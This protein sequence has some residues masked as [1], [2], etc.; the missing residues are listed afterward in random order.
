MKALFAVLNMGL[1]HATRSLGLINSLMEKGVEITVAST[2]RSLHLLKDEFKDSLYSISFVDVPDYAIEYSKKGPL[3]LKLILQIPSLFKK[4]K[5]ENNFTEK[6]VKKNKYDLIISDHRYGF[7]HKN[8]PSFFITHQL[9]L[10]PPWKFKLAKKI[11]AK[12]HSLLL[13]NFNMVII[14][15]F[16]DDLNLSGEL[17]HNIF[18]NNIKKYYAGPWSSIEKETNVPEYKYDVLALISGPEPQRTILEDKLTAILKNYSGKAVMVIGKPG[19]PK[20]KNKKETKE[21]ND[22]TVFT[23]LNRQEI[24]KL[25]MQCKIIISRSGY[26]TVM[27]IAG[28][29]KKA[30]F[31]PTPGQSEQE[32]LAE[33]YADNNWYGFI[34]QKEIDILPELL[35]NDQMDFHGF[36]GNINAE[37][38]YDK[39]AEFLLSHVKSNA[40][41]G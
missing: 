17:S 1:G 22:L 14:P 12:L 29:K 16:A 38:N 35:K 32:Y 26:T 2:G 5:L 27:E 11:S 4:I 34:K 6:L 19:E 23:H 8:I 40:L 7:F 21:K 25:I 36:P 18:S 15:D 13:K 20:K 24:H 28:L 3:I 9:L 31:I 10:M 30:V 39:T 41:S 37:E 33:Y